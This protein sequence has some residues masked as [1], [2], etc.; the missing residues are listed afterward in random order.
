MTMTKYDRCRFFLKIMSAK[1]TNDVIS[2]PSIQHHEFD[3]YNVHRDSTVLWDTN[4]EHHL[5]LGLCCTITL[6]KRH[7]GS[8]TTVE[9][10]CLASGHAVWRQATSFQCFEGDE[11]AI[12]EMAGALVRIR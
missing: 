11:A 6:S 12:T 7:A 4:Y 9:T 10:P 3:V 1:I 8:G 5:P 2:V